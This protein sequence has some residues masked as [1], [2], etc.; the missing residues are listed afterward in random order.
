MGPIDNQSRDLE[1]WMEVVS[2]WDFYTIKSY[3]FQK[4]LKYIKLNVTFEKRK[5]YRINRR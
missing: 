1:K 2:E 3:Y 5:V 4:I